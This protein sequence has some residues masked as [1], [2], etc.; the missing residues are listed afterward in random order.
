[1]KENIDDLF[2][3]HF[4]ESL[5]NMQDPTIDLVKIA[6]EKIASRK[7]V[8]ASG[9]W[10]FPFFFK[11]EI[12]VYQAAF[13]A[14]LIAVTVLYYS[15]QKYSPEKALGEKT[16]PANSSINS[17]TVLAGLTQHTL[18]ESAVKS[19]TVLTSIMTF[20]AKN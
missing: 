5:A 4:D 2:K 10:S 19:S 17:S 6:R 9:K 20:V 1:M 16:Y 3:Q 8:S 15:K 12:S 18:N 14:L 7:S 11:V 13:A